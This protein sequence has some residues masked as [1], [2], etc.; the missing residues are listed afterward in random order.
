LQ[1]GNGEDEASHPPPEQ[2]I[3]PLGPALRDFADTAALVA[4]L[5]L[6]ICVDTA[7]AHLAGALGRP[8]WV[9]LP[10]IGTDWRW[11][12]DREDSPWYPGVMRLF[13]QAGTEG[14]TETIEKM[15]AALDIWRGNTPEP[16]G[17]A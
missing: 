11:L 5:D 4:Q 15:T 12:E 9:L 6:V 7:I 2:P 10:H 17:E 1:K 13:R 8:C 3:L 14:W 16:G